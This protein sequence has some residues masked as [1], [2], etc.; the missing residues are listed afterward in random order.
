MSFIH[1]LHKIS[2]ALG[3]PKPP[4]A[5]AMKIPG[6]KPSTTAAAPMAPAKPVAPAASAQPT[7]PLAAPTAPMGGSGMGAMRPQAPP[8]GAPVKVKDQ[9]G[10]MS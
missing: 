3:A 5:S 9:Y 10:R 7:A 4:G 1:G 2:A 8:H 6:M